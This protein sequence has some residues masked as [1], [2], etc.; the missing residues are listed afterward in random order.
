MGG[1][2]DALTSA[3][4]DAG[5]YAIFALMLLDAVFPAGSEIVMLY[6]GALA[7]G[8]FL[9]ESGVSLF[10]AEIESTAWAYVVV[11]LAGTIGYWI[12]SVIGWAIGLYPARAAWPLAPRHPGKPRAG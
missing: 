10:G 2:T 6:G 5:I 1:V 7:A 12:G 3:V 4:G 11:V 8:A 9:P